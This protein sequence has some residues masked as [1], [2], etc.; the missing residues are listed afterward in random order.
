MKKI[1]LFAAAAI[2]ALSAS[3]QTP[4]FAHVNFNEL[5]MLTPAADSARAKLALIQKEN[6]ETFSSMYQEFQTKYQQYEQKK[7]TWTPTILANKE[8]ELSDIQNRLQE[9]EQSAS[10]DLQQM[11]SQLMSP[12]Q[13]K[14]MEVVNELAKAGGYIYVFEQGSMLYI[15]A[16]QSKDLTPDAR[17]KLGIPEG[18]TLETLQQELQAQASQSAQ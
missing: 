2:A 12:I 16:A 5:I 3:A 13:Q 15:D 9:F 14:A 6:Q 4:K 7:S 1:I 17:K 8:K 10:Q 18:R 11:Q